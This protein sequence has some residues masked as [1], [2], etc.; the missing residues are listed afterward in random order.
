MVHEKF[1]GSL[2]TTRASLA[3]AF[4]PPWY[5]TDLADACKVEGNHSVLLLE[6]PRVG[7]TTTNAAG[8][9]L[10]L[11]NS[12]DSSN[13]QETCWTLSN[14]VAGTPA[15]MAIVCDA[16]GVVPGVIEQLEGGVWEVQKEANFVISNIATAGDG[17]KAPCF[18]NR[19]K[20]ETV[21]EDIYG[22]T[23]RFNSLSRPAGF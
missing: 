23:L 2:L 9:L 3:S 7:V 20:K 1:T 5:R 22:N 12:G 4:N 21:K 15:Q 18:R 6:H 13:S 11:R 8:A 10:P 16:P 17:E 19:S 14:I